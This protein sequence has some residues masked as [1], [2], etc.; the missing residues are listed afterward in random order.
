MTDWVIDLDGVMWRGPEPI[1][2]STDAVAALLERGE[3]VLFC[4]NNSSESGHAHA[5]RLL[6]QGIAPGFDVVTSADAVSTM[7]RPGERVVVL[8]GPGLSAALAEV[9]AVTVAAGD[10][11]PA[12]LVAAASRVAAGDDTAAPFDAVVVGLT[13]EVDYHQLD[14]AAAATRAGARLLASNSD[15]TFPGADGLHPGCGAIVA[16]VEAAAGR[17]ATVAGK[18]H[19]PMVTLIRQRLGLGGDAGPRHVVVVGDRPDTDGA[20]ASAL[21]VDF[22]LVLSGITTEADLPVGVPTARVAATLGDLVLAGRR[23]GPGAAE[24]RR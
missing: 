2:G 12:A 13:R 20:L 14:V 10:L 4:S 23:G 8:G 1:A 9:G 6:E 5:E 11:D 16:A 22:A 19:R 15:T 21:G 7:V 17:R 3:R 24:G 18:P